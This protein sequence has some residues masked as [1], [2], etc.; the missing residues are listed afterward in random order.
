[1]SFGI[2]YQYPFITFP[3]QGWQC[4]VCSKVYSPDVPSCF[5]CGQNMTVTCTDSSK[6]SIP[7]IQ[8]F[9]FDEEK[10]KK[11]MENLD[12]VLKKPYNP[13]TKKEDK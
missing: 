9:T 7:Q 11:H 8:D 12:D 3:R 5:T 13:D 1:M 2:P 10:F 6:V 4:P